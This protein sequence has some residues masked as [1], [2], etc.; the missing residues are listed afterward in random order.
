MSEIERL[1]DISTY[2]IRIARR[3]GFQDAD[4]EDIVSDTLCKALATYG[5][6]LDSIEGL[7]SLLITIL[8]H[9]IADRT[10][11][12]QKMRALSELDALAAE[13][14]CEDSLQ[15]AC[16]AGGL[17]PACLRS[18]MEVLRNE[19]PKLAERAQASLEGHDADSKR[20]RR[21]KQLLTQW[22]ETRQRKPRDGTIEV[23]N[24]ICQAFKGFKHLEILTLGVPFLWVA[25]VDTLQ[26]FYQ[27]Y[28]GSS[29]K[30]AIHYQ[31]GVYFCEA[32]FRKAADGFPV[33]M[34]YVT[35]VDEYW[36]DSSAAKRDFDHR[37]ALDWDFQLKDDPKG[38]AFLHA[39]GFETIA[40]FY[41]GQRECKK[42]L[43]VAR[44]NKLQTIDVLRPDIGTKWVRDLTEICKRSNEIRLK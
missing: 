4:A 26:P 16:D 8:K 33:K 17:R 22:A 6:R 43:F 41:A 13:E 24:E 14:T 19:R 39:T 32:L 18:V 38:L 25:P 9:Q 15:L 27:R 29:K 7:K 44:K 35:K 28:Y 2:L 23:R 21:T 40:V 20:R 34:T 10:K 42:P 3:S 1:I 37:C 5:D 11:K 30:A 12:G 31:F 36:R